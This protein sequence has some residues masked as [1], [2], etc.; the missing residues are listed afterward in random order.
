[1]RGGAFKPRTSPYAFQGLGEEGLKYMKIAAEKYHLV[2]V[3]EIMDASQIEAAEDYV[4]IFQIGTRN[5]Q[6]FHLLKEIGKAGKPVFLKRGFSATY[7]DFLMA[8][9]Y[10]LAQGNPN[11]ILCE[12]GIRTHETYSRN[13]L[14]I[15]AVPILKELSHLPVFVDPSH[16]VGIRKMVPPM[17]KAAVAAGCDGLMIEVHPHPDEAVS[18]KDQTLNPMEFQKLM[19]EVNKIRAVN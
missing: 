2:T 16:G 3:S 14:D 1:M 9:E 6:N 13:T 15:A 18:D 4:D 17:A 10:I 5:M 12:R 8:A 11:V 19:A 7:V